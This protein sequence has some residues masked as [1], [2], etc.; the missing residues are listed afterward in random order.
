MRSDRGIMRISD[1]CWSKV[2]LSE[3]VKCKVLLI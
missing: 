1:N 3:F 2:C